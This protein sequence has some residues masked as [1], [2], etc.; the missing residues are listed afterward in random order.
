MEFVAEPTLPLN[1]LGTGTAFA[2]ASRVNSRAG[3]SIVGIVVLSAAGGGF[4][5]IRE[6]DAARASRGTPGKPATAALLATPGETRSALRVSSAIALEGAHAQGIARSLAAFSATRAERQKLEAELLAEKKA[7]LLASRPR[8]ERLL[9]EKPALAAGAA[10]AW[11]KLGDRD[12]LFVVSR[13]LVGCAADPEVRPILL[14]AAAGGDPAHRE[15]ALLALASARDEQALPLASAALEDAAALPAV[16]AAGAW[17][18]AASD[19]EAPPSA[20]STARAIA[21]SPSQDPH[22]RA[23]ALHLIACAPGS[24][25]RALADG[26]LAEDAAPA[27]LTVA[28]AR[29]AL[30]AGEDRAQV[31]RALAARSDPTGLCARAASM[32]EGSP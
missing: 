21:A 25:D 26:V 22:L 2:H 14:E 7:E 24:R 17:A 9:R 30:E 4:A 23:E 1:G 11:K 19:A 5:L 29:L 18:L 12:E 10:R 13:A 8:L 27:E 20:V 16:R 31:A 3:R 28:A 15:I 32:L 6:G